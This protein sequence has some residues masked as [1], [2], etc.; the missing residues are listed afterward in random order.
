MVL[1]PY[2][3]VT[4]HSCLTPHSS[5]ESHEKRA[6]SYTSD[7]S[8]L[9]IAHSFFFFFIQCAVFSYVVPSKQWWPLL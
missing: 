9:C 5:Y 1:V 7:S 3:L 6:L 2:L 4:H 8:I